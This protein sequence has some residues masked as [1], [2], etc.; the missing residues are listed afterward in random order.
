M[1]G[2]RSYGEVL[3]KFEREGFQIGPHKAFQIA[4]DAAR[5]RAI[6]VSEM[7]PD[8]AR[9]LLPVR[10]TSIQAALGLSLPELPVHARVA[11]MPRAS[12]TIPLALNPS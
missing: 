8:L 5:V 10:A 3:A 7:A 11:I 2:L 6:L 9:P 4:R 12:S 1:E